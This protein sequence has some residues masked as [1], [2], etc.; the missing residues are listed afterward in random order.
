MFLTTTWPRLD[1]WKLNFSSTIDLIILIGIHFFKDFS[2]ILHSKVGVV[3]ECVT[4]K[5]ASWG[6]RELNWIEIH[7]MTENQDR[8]HHHREWRRNCCVIAGVWPLFASWCPSIAFVA[9]WRSLS[10]RRLKRTN[11]LIIWSAFLATLYS[12]DCFQCTNIW[13]WRIKDRALAESAEAE[14]DSNSLAVPSKKRKESNDWK[15]CSTPWISSTTIL[16]S[17]PTSQ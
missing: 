8:H 2:I 17:C 1:P 16:T 6:K 10:S 4:G 14:E 13:C 9:S 12:A 5:V 15:P 11:T 3:S 7:R